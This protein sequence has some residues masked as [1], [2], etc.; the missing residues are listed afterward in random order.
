VTYLHGVAARTIQ[1]VSIFAGVQMLT[2]GTN[3]LPRAMMSASVTGSFRQIETGREWLALRV[4]QSSAV[5][6]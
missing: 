5:G 4:M 1:G 2:P 6:P 3:R